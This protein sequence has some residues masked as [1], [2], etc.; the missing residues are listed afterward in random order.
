M[1]RVIIAEYIRFD[2]DICQFSPQSVIKWGKVVENVIFLSMFV[3][4]EP[5]L[6]R[7]GEEKR[8]DNH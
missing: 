6:S 7:I 8:K 3:L 2:G 5:T 4:G 1:P